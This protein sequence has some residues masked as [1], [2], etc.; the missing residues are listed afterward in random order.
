MPLTLIPGNPLIKVYELLVA[1]SVTCFLVGEGC[2]RPLYDK[3]SQPPALGILVRL[4]GQRLHVRDLSREDR[5]GLEFVRGP[6]IDGFHK[7]IRFILNLP[8]TAPVVSE[9]RRAIS[10][11]EV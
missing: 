2:G 7:K 9:A 6:T 4:P 8:Y 5:R 11:I 3:R 1:E 10:R